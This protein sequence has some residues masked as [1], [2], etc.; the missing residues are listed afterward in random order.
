MLS[1]EDNDTLCRV[2]PGTPMGEMMRE[3]WIPAVRSDEL[4]SPDCPPVRIRLLGED[5]IAFR[6]TS[7]ATGSDGLQR[8]RPN[9]SGR[10]MDLRTRHPPPSIKRGAE[11]TLP[12][13]MEGLL[14]TEPRPLP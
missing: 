14:D 10:R 9:G 13:R 8:P 2:G 3:Y 12:G 4:P 11:T 7:G 6:A 5:L 1:K